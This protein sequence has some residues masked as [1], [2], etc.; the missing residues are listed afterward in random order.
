MDVERNLLGV[1]GP[2]L[3]AEAVVVFSIGQRSEGVIVGG[4]GVLEVLAVSL[5]VLDLEESRNC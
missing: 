5:G 3:V 4:D 2:A 1:G